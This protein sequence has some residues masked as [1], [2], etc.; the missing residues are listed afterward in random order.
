[1]GDGGWSLSGRLPAPQLHDIERQLSCGRAVQAYAN[2]KVGQWL[3]RIGDGIVTR[4]HVHNNAAGRP[5]DIIGQV[6]RIFTIAGSS[7]P[8]V[9]YIRLVRPSEAKIRSTDYAEDELLFPGRVGYSASRLDE[10]K[11]RCALT[12]A[13]DYQQYQAHR[14]WAARLTHSPLPPPSMATFFVRYVD[15]S[16][17]DIPVGA[18]RRLVW[19]GHAPKDKYLDLSSPIHMMAFE[20]DVAGLNRLLRKGVSPLARDCNNHTVLHYACWTGHLRTIT[21]LLGRLGQGVAARTETVA[22]VKEC[23][24]LCQSLGFVTAH[25]VI[26]RFR[27][28]LVAAASTKR[29][30]RIRVDVSEHDLLRFASLS[31]LSHT[32]AG[33]VGERAAKLA[34]GSGNSNDNSSNGA[35]CAADDEDSAFSTFINK[36]SN[37]PAELI[38]GYLDSFLRKGLKGKREDEVERT[39]QRVLDLFRFVQGK[40]MFEAFYQDSLSRRL[41]HQKTAS[42]EYE[43]LLVSKLKL[44]CGANFTSHLEGML[45][46][47]DISAQL[48]ADF[49]T[50]LEVTRQQPSMELYVNVLT[51]SNW[52]TYPKVNVTL[53]PDVVRM[54][55]LFSQFYCNKHKNRKLQWQPSQGQCILG[56]SF[57]RGNKELIV[58][59]FQA[60]VLLLF[61]DSQ[62]LT[63]KEIQ[64]A[65]GIDMPTLKRTLQSLACGKIR[66]LAKSPKGKEVDETDKFIVNYKFSN[67]RRRVKINQIQMKQTQAETDATSEKVFQDRVFAIDAAI[68]RVMKA[69]KTLKHNFLLTEL[70]QQ[71]KFPC[72]PVDIKK[73]VETLIERDYLE[74]DPNDPQTYKYLA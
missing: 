48:N 40:D 18:G 68:V 43:K 60:I 50:H 25:R 5:T 12:T 46:D 74:R 58:S 4:N 52:P 31:E 70:F 1:M 63:C 14:A 66:V 69:R 15:E 27:A 35:T 41:L 13:T 45:K 26:S 38:A 51:T 3:I 22:V 73:R 21:A 24:A 64:Q 54:Q 36:R 19:Q 32:H 57:Q 17:G 39:F 71:L 59:L 2:A 23:E 56:A 42:T 53:P 33:A 65:T 9:T 47:I 61:N 49:K 72:K 16:P 55:E 34:H 37:K 44:E 29:A 6:V 28:R 11:A 62:K 67:E 8:F 30:T 10:I 20:G 7:V